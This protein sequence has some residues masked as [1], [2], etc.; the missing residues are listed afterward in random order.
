MT[1]A[2]F[3]LAGM[4]VVISARAIA[5]AGAL[6][7]PW[8]LIEEPFRIG[9]GRWRRAWLHDL[10]TRKNATESHVR[11]LSAPDPH[12]GA[13]DTSEETLRAMQYDLVL[14]QFYTARIE[15]AER[16]SSSP[17]SRSATLVLIVFILAAALLLDAGSGALLHALQGAVGL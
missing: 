6:T 5:L 9:V 3:S 13:Q 4:P 2:R 1:L 11:R 12:T 16:A 8:L 10:R 15:E 7:L 14:L 17:L